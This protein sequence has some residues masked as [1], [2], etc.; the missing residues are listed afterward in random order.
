MGKKLLVL[1][2]LLIAIAAWYFAPHS[3]VIAP[4][5]ERTPTPQSTLSV[6]P[7]ATPLLVSD[8]EVVLENLSVPWDIALTPDGTLLVTERKGN[9]VIMTKQDSRKIA[10][11]GVHEIGEGGLLGIA[12]HPNFAEN[13]WLYLY[14]TTRRSGRN[15]NI[16]NRYV[17]ENNRLS[18]MKTVVGNIPAGNNHN[19][20]RMRFGPDGYLYIGTGEGGVS[21]RS[22]S[23]SSLG[24]KILR[25]TDDGKIPENNPFETSPLYSYG[26][27]NVQGLA[28]DE[29]GI[30]WATEHGRSGLLSGYDEVNKIQ[31]GKDYGWPTI[32]GPQE[33]EGLISPFVQSGANTTWAPSGL[34]YYKDNLFFAGLRGQ[35]LYQLNLST[36]KITT[37]FEKEYGRLRAVTLGHDGYLYISTSNRDGRGAPKPGDDKIYKI[38]IE[39][40]FQE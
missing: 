40:F 1:F 9:L 27:R 6:T 16:V 25:I 22:R 11:E 15:F 12:L 4:G 7:T 34:V 21:N 31:I 3:R 17:F 23:L 24:G 8:K 5:V 32:Q 20:G 18:Q 39:S 36:K 35:A 29:N 19:G 33:G 13:H 26:H 30:M 37:H 38:K 14:M 28:W 2:L 10:V